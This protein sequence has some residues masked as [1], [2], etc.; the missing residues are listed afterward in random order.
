MDSGHRSGSAWNHSE[1]VPLLGLKLSLGTR[2]SPPG[3][4]PGVH[5]VPSP[6]RSVGPDRKGAQGAESLTAMKG[7]QPCS[8]ASDRTQQVVAG[9]A[10]DAAW[11]PLGHR[12]PGA[13]VR[14]GSVSWRFPSSGERNVGM[15][16]PKKYKILFLSPKIAHVV[17]S[18]TKS[19]A[20]GP[21]HTHTHN[22][23][24]LSRG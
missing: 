13:L 20:Q 10:K 2:H 6:S 16:L 9:L 11:R 14:Q 8:L 18:S 19:L 12:T 21:Y 7:R 24:P 22:P 5:P 1:P 17:L 15:C 23:S 4:D 3:C